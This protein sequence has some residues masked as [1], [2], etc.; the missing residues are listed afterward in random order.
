MHRLT[1]DEAGAR[2][3]VVWPLVPSLHFSEPFY[4]SISYY[5]SV[6]R[7]IHREKVCTQ[8]K[9]YIYIFA[10]TTPQILHKQG[11]KKKLRKSSFSTNTKDSPPKT[12]CAFLRWF[13]LRETP[14]GLARLRTRKLRP[15][16]LLGDVGRALGGRR[17]AAHAPSL[18]Q[19]WSVQQQ[20]P[21]RE[22]CSQ[23]CLSSRFCAARLETTK[24]KG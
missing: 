2:R 24:R 20:E 15:R 4:F 16:L 14:P 6:T 23:R 10:L 5:F 13:I 12:P 11:W 8:L 1:G 7:I 22:R 17:R 9:I 18:H 3:G 19:P 21:R